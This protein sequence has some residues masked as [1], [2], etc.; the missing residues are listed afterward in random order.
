MRI[1]L[2]YYFSMYL[3]EKMSTVCVPK[4][5]KQETMPTTRK[6]FLYPCG[7]V[8]YNLGSTHLEKEFSSKE[9]VIVDTEAKNKLFWKKNT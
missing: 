3:I 4:A 2:I 5:T 7:L 8:N 6:V 9:E 1:G